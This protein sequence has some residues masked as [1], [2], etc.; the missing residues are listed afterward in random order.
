MPGPVSLTVAKIYPS[1][2]CVVSVRVP[3]PS[4]AWTALAQA[5]ATRHVWFEV[6]NN[7]TFFIGGSRDGKMQNFLTPA[8]FYVVRQ[9]EWK[10]T[11]PYFIIDGGMQIATSGFH[12]YNHN[13]ISEMRMIF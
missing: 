4:I 5:H 7:A 2:L 3:R 9:K 12:T 8:A 6:E 1:E 10:A 13:L 11:H